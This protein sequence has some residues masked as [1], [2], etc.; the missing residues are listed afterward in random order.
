ML[1]TQE[2]VRIH[3]M[4][5]IHLD[6]ELTG[7]P[8]A[9]EA[10]W[11]ERHFYASLDKLRQ[12][13]DIANRERPDCVVCTG[14]V[15]DRAQP[16]ATFMKEWNRIEPPKALVLGNHD[17]DLGGEAFEEQFGIAGE[18]LTAGSRFNRSFAVRKGETA[19]RVLLLDTYVG[20]DGQRLYDTCEGTIT[21]EAFVWLE[22]QFLSCPE[23]VIL[24]FAHNGLG[25]PE[26]YFDRQ[27]VARFSELAALTAERGK[28]II[29][30]AGHHH[31]HPIA[32]V[33]IQPGYTFVNGVAMI[34]E[35]TSSVNVVEIYAD[36]A[37]RID[38]RPVSA[39]DYSSR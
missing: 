33:E 1:T 14:D 19:V 12:A 31:V 3:W 32:T 30:L 39:A 36:G 24:L 22:Q 7:R 5:D 4:T 26:E 37:C 17:L 9:P 16:L 20:E 11:R 13:V 25:G 28:R 10:I 27:A 23:Q 18:P 35:T 8:D 6:D 34:C 29:H 15:I 2:P 21:N 38:Y